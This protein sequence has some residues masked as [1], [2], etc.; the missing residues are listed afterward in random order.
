MRVVNA[1][2]GVRADVPA[3]VVAL[4]GADWQPEKAPAKKAPASAG[5]KSKAEG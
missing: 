1:R 5:G 4:L 2:T 3:D